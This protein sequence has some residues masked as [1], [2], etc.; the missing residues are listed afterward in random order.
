MARKAR[1]LFDDLR[2]AVEDLKSERE[3]KITLRRTKI[4]KPAP[5]EITPDR[6]VEI[7]ER[8][9]GLSRTV[10][11]RRLHI[12]ERTLER[13]EQGR[14][15]PNEQAIALI[16]LVAKRPEVMQDLTEL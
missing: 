15:K 4:A 2:D 3:G 5:L 7:R 8:I 12:K 1:R 11:A 9:L 14:G 10:F 6:I 16:L 13:W